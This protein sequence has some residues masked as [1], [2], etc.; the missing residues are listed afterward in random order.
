MLIRISNREIIQIIKFNKKIY[1]VEL[2]EE[3]L[4]KAQNTKKCYKERV[5]SKSFNNLKHRQTFKIISSKNKKY[6]HNKWL[7]KANKTIIRP[8]MKPQQH[9]NLLRLINKIYNRVCPTRI[10]EIKMKPMKKTLTWMVTISCFRKIQIS[11]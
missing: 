1:Q 11:L 8:I 3:F 6:K 10:T 7:L 5:N 9:F 2:K 4:K